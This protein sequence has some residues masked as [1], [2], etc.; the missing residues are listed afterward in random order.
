MTSIGSMGVPGSGLMGSGIAAA[1]GR[2]VVCDTLPEQPDS[3]RK[4]GRRF[5]NY[6]VEPPVPGDFR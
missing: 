3:G 5:Y 4:S 2:T 6:S 1:G